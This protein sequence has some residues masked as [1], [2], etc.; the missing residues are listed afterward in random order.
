MGKNKCNN[1]M[2]EFLDCHG[3][4]SGR[5]FHGLV[6]WL[7]IIAAAALSILTALLNSFKDWLE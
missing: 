7:V 6:I 2:N 3:D 4:G 1:E 5:R